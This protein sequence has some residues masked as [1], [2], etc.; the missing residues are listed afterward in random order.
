M[1]RPRAT[2][3]RG[4]RPREGVAPPREAGADGQRRIRLMEDRH[5]TGASASSAQ[6][7]GFTNVLYLIVAT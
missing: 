2:S 4:A 3:A 1:C 6:L 7:P 5:R